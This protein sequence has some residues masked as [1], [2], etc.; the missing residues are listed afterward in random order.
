[1]LSLLPLLTSAVTLVLNNLI[2]ESISLKG[3]QH[4]GVLIEAFGVNWGGERPLIVCDNLIL[5]IGE[6]YYVY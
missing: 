1:M 5:I 3:L 2:L 4:F 6:V